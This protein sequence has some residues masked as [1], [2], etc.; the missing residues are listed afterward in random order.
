MQEGWTVET[1]NPWTK[2]DL[3]ARAKDAGDPGANPR[4]AEN[5]PTLEH[6]LIDT[7]VTGI[8]KQGEHPKLCSHFYH[9][10]PKRAQAPERLVFTGNP[11]Y[12]IQQA[13]Y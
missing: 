1:Q 2:W 6:S 11:S 13:T 9:G 12:C 3:K 4:T 10:V 5:P 8:L 7:Q